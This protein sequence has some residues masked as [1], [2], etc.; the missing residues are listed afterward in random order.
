MVEYDFMMIDLVWDL[1]YEIC[2]K[3]GVKIKDDIRKEIDKIIL[4]RCRKIYWQRG[5][6][7]VKDWL[8]G[9]G[10]WWIGNFEKELQKAW[11]R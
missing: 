11:E 7:R 3:M 8:R 4:E 6:E 5:K 1:I 9:K 10:N 2:E